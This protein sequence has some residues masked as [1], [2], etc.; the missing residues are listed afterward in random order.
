MNALQSAGYTT[1]MKIGSL[2]Y[3]DTLKEEGGIGEKTAELISTAMVQHFGKGAQTAYSYEQR[4]Q[5]FQL[6]CTTCSKAI[7][8]LLGGG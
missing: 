6:R 4:W 3:Q 5:K 7:D 1:L 2:P 8:T